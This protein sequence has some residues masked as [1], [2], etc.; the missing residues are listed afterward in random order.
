MYVALPQSDVATVDLKNSSLEFH[1][2]LGALATN[3]SGVMT[4]TNTSGVQGAI[5]EAFDEDRYSVVYSDGVIATITANKFEYNSGSNTIT[6]KGLS[7]IS[8]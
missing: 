1:A 6:L 8:D 2:Q 7:T 3:G 4:I 5:F